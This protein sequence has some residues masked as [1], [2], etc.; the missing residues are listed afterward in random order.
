MVGIRLDNRVLRVYECLLARPGED[1]RIRELQALVPRANVS[2]V[3]FQLV[4]GH[5]AIVEV[6]VAQ[7]PRWGEAP[8][9]YIYGQ[10]S[11]PLRPQLLT[12]KLVAPAQK[13]VVKTR[14]MS[15]MESAQ[16]DSSSVNYGKSSDQVR[17]Y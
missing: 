16:L 6:T 4:N 8:A 17:K 1:V 10:F 15:E 14:Y 2:S 12:A 7:T 13:P 9:R 5:G 3:L 11:P